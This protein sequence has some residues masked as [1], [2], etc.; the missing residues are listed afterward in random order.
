M[1]LFRWFTVQGD[2]SPH[3]ICLDWNGSLIAW[4]QFSDWVITASY[5]V[6]PA[7]LLWSIKK[8]KARSKKD[9]LYAVLFATFIFS[10]GTTHLISAYNFFHAYY[11]LEALFLGFTA[12][13]SALTA[14]LLRWIL[15]EKQDDGTL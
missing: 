14:C 6:I 3:A 12:T 2:Y 1:G 15:K 13:V 4:M 10:C 11:R 7:I 8:R 5:Y 9:I